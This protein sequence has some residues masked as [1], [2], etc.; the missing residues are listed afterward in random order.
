MNR[1]VSRSFAQVASRKQRM[2]LT[3]RTPY[4]TLVEK[5]TDFKR[6]IAKTN[7]GILNIQNRSPSA[8]YIL[9]PGLLRVKTDKEVAGLPSDLFHTGGFAVVHPDNSCEI[10][11][12]EAVSRK[13][14]AVEQLGK[15]QFEPN[16]GGVSGKFVDKIRNSTTKVF[17][18]ISNK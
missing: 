17:S 15:G 6:I 11:L 7:E 16:E 9:E 2:E 10:H 3:I 5:F 8:L 13:E 18:R 14:I 12:T 4:K 1:L